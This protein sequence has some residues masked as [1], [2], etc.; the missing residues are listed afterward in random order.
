MLPRFCALYG[1]V[2]ASLMACGPVYTEVDF[3]PLSEA[4][5]S[6]AKQPLAG[7]GGSAGAPD[8]AGSAPGQGGGAGAP[9]LPSPAA[10][11]AS[12]GS[13]GTGGEAGSGGNAGM[14]A[15]SCALVGAWQEQPYTLG[16]RVVSTCKVP[17]NGACPAEETREFECQPPTGAVGLGWCRDRQPGVINGWHEAWLMREACPAR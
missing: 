15:S 12:A 13:G 4:G 10:A 14:A 3:E 5:A 11:G 1:P 6:T 16:E 7:S 8:A 2:L 17:Y 9:E